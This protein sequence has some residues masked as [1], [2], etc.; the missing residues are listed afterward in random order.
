MITYSDLFNDLADLRFK[1]HVKH[2]VGLVE[3]QV[4]AAAQ[5]GFPRF[6]EVDEAA[7]RS[8]HDLHTALDVSQLQKKTR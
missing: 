7:G 2:S 3:H 5:I 4:R 8:D 6:Q 1:T